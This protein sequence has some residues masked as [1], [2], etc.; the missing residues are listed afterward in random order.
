MLRAVRRAFGEIARR[1][2]AIR[3]DLCGRH[4]Y[5]NQRALQLEALPP[6]S[7]KVWLRESPLFLSAEELRTIRWPEPPTPSHL[8]GQVRIAARFIC[9]SIEDAELTR[10]NL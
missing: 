3:I 9:K 2:E 4:E 7:S 1:P 5:W 6:S 8:A 10:P